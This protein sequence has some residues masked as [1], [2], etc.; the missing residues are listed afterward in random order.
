VHI[1]GGTTDHER[2]M[3]QPSLTTNGLA[4]NI[5]QQQHN[6]G[7][8]NMGH[9][10]QRAEDDDTAYSEYKRR[11]KGIQSESHVARRRG[12]EREPTFRKNMKQEKPT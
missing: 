7:I 4:C 10:R 9:S 3:S 2:E 5:V 6:D 8:T 11:E 12:L 1:R